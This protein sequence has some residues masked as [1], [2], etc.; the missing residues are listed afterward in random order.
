MSGTLFVMILSIL[1][2]GHP[3]LRKKTTTVE[4][5]TSE[6]V[7][8]GH[9]LLETIK[10]L[11]MVGCAAPQVGSRWSLI[12]VDV[13]RSK[14]LSW[15]EMDGQAVVVES[16]MPL[17]LINPDI[18]TEGNLTVAPEACDSFWK[19]RADIVRTET[20]AVSGLN[21]QGMPIAFR[22][23]GRL[24]RVIQHEWDHLQGI[25]F[26]DRMSPEVLA[27]FNN[28]FEQLQ[29]QSVQPS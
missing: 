17:V 27:S 1:K 10:E 9:D 18:R 15:L 28:Q 19:I 29:A 25:L 14:Y 23:G 3:I 21:I 26:I 5:I 2:Y 24:A 16:L 7:Q 20:V 13:S 4:R 8:L 22:C 6:I 11:Q 12:A